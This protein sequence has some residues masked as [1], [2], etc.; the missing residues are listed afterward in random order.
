MRLR[1]LK[2]LLGCHGG[3]S[4]VTQCLLQV[5]G[6]SSRLMHSALLIIGCLKEK[7][8]RFKH[9]YDV[10][11][12]IVRPEQN[13]VFRLENAHALIVTISCSHRLQD[14]TSN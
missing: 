12:F 7:A 1:L 10:Y 13:P 3:T 6:V 4:V 2:N 14:P 8:L 11:R 5:S 9:L